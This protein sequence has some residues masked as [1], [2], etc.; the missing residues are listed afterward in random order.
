MDLITIG[1]T[2]ISEDYPTGVD[3]RY[4]SEFEELQTEIDKLSFPSASGG[5]NWQR[6]SSLAEKVLSEKSK[7]L[8]VGSYFAVSQIYVADMAGLATGIQVYHDLLDTFWDTL[9]PLKKRMRGRIA[10]IEWWL[11]KS[12]IAL[13][14]L[15]PVAL[16]ADQVEHIKKLLLRVDELLRKY[17]EEPPLL[18]PL[19]RFID[20]IPLQDAAQDVRE[21][22]PLPDSK[23]KTQ[24]VAKPEKAAAV[25][26]VPPA[27]TAGLTSPADMEKSLRSALQTMQHVGD[28]FYNRDRTDP[29]GYRWRRTAGWSMIQA[30]PPATENRTMIPPPT[31]YRATHNRLSGLSDSG[32]W[33]SLL[34]ASENNYKGALLWLD[35]NRFTAEAMEGLGEQFSDAYAAVCQESSF[36]VNRLAGL[37]DLCFA[38]GT[39]LADS[40]TKQWLQ[41]IGFAN[42]GSLLEQPV[43]ADTDEK[44]T[45]SM[46]MQKAQLLIKQK[47]LPEAVRSVQKELSRSFSRKERLLWRLGLSQLLTD[48]K[49]PKLAMPHLEGIIEDIDLYKLEEWDPELA[50]KALRVV[51]FGLKV[52]GDKSTK[53]Q[54]DKI[55]ARIAKLDPAEALA[56]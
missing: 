54:L 39:P 6:V 47:K 28:F 52:G 9:F 33:E 38:D 19:E 43:A 22:E 8:L 49:K 20:S 31:E 32:N 37:E 34:E 26:P 51:W 45:M 30:L 35:L 48:T 14:V 41:G 15:Q 25:K 13:Q 53:E 12:D 29:R 23:P 21:V 46:T 10:A 4:E 55:L 3:I 17:L 50:L 56:L 40:E 36:L 11:E 42:S 27:D 7:D 18:R 1:K 5:I 24:P 2:P 44:N 16:P